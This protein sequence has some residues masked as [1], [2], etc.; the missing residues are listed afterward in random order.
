MPVYKGT[1]RCII[2]LLA[3]LF[4]KCHGNYVDT[5]LLLNVVKEQTDFEK[6]LN[7]CYLTY[8]FFRE[9]LGALTVV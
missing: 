2:K 5:S 9:I 1:G 4:L 6:V 3:A 7:M 8:C